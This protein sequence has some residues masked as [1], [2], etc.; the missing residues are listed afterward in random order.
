MNKVL[1]RTKAVPNYDDYPLKFYKAKSKLYRISLP[2]KRNNMFIRMIA[3]ID[4]WYCNS[5]LLLSRLTRVTKKMQKTSLWIWNWISHRD[6]RKASSQ[7]LVTR[8]AWATGL[9]NSAKQ[10][11]VLI[12]STMENWIRLR[13]LSYCL[14]ITS[15]R[16][17][18]P[19]ATKFWLICL[20]NKGFILMWVYHLWQNEWLFW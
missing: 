17:S 5:L 4:S 18:W 14:K 10:F 20:V 8:A 2:P 3:A 12:E 9:L 6:Y 19:P 7:W 11:H 1:P 16:I 13:V 15:P